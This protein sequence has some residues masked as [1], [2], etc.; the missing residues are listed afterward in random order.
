ML[1][2]VEEVLNV[3]LHQEEQEEMVEEELEVQEHQDL[4]QKEVQE[5]LTQV[6]EVEDLVMIEVVDQEDRE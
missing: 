1:E 2:E 4:Y 6:V 3:L 5:L